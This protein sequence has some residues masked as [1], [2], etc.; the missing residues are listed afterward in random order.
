MQADYFIL[1]GLNHFGHLVI[2]VPWFLYESE[3]LDASVRQSYNHGH[4]GGGEDE[5]SSL[6]GVIP[7]PDPLVLQLLSIF[8]PQPALNSP[9]RQHILDLILRLPRKLSIRN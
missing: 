6:N 5:A 8:A 7:R 4:F 1:V 3:E 9:Q 2:N